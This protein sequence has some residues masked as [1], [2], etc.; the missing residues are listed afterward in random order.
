[1]SSNRPAISAEREY[2]EW[3]YPHLA[4]TPVMLTCPASHPSRNCAH[5]GLGDNLVLPAT[6]FSHSLCLNLGGDERA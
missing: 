3:S 1:M 5:K 4:T 2:V 6:S